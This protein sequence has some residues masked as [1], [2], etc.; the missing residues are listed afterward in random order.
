M[1]ITLVAER[2]RK[3]GPD[4]NYSKKSRHRS[5]DERDLGKEIDQSMTQPL[6]NFH[7]GPLK[8]SKIG[9]SHSFGSQAGQNCLPQPNRAALDKSYQ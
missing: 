1:M 2:Y 6:G 7:A 5:S 3:C 8:T 4:K 9:S